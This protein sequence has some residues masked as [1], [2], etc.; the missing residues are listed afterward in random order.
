[1][2]LKWLKLYILDSILENKNSCTMNSQVE[3]L[4]LCS[5]RF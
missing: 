1:L 2:N 4:S 5:K 3:L